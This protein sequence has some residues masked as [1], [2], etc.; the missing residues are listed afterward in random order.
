M[1]LKELLFGVSI[2]SVLGSTSVS[3]EGVTSD[4]RALGANSLFVAIRGEHHDGHDHISDAVK[5]GAVAV[6]CEELPKKQKD[7]VTYVQTPQS[8]SAY[9]VVASNYHNNPSSTIEN[10]IN[11]HIYPATHTTPDPMEINSFLAKMVEAG[12]TH[13]FMEVS[14]HGID[15][16]RIGGLQF[17]G[18]VFTNLTHDHLDYHK[19]FES[20]RDTKKKFFDLLPE[21]AFALTN[22]DDKNGAYMLQNCTAK[23]H[24]FA[25]KNTAEFKAKIIEHD[26]SGMQ[27]RIDGIET[28]VALVGDF[29]ASNML[30]VYACTQLLGENIDQSLS[31]LSAVE[32]VSGRFNV[33]SGSH[34]VRAIVDYAHTPD[35]LQLVLETINK[36]RTGNEI[37]ITVFG[38]GGGRD[39]AKRPL[40]GKIASTLSDKVIFTSDNPRNEDPEKIIKQIEAGVPAEHFKK[41]ISISSR[42]Q[43][44]KTACQLA[45]KG[46][47]IL[48]AGKG[49]ETYQDVKGE[50]LAFDDVKEL[51]NHLQNKS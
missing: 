43:A 33:V 20:Y 24:S 13:C 44:I 6:L 21:T 31:A 9:A 29:N 5:K 19:T 23:K 10:A 35:A 39:K 50:R 38:C 11:E 46:D 45:H 30:A 34:P 8:R 47:I 26:F 32:P 12:V 17:R 41:Y 25:L 16:H 28:W 36:I 40:M 37:L 2:D 49:H 15:Q 51:K 22:N 48:L 14:S 4:S 7:G 18:G 1:Q 3:I 27:L 42:S